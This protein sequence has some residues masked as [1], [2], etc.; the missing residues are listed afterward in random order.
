MALHVFLWVQMY[1]ATI[2]FFLMACALKRGNCI[3]KIL[4]ILWVRNIRNLTYFHLFRKKIKD[5]SHISL[6]LVFDCWQSD[7]HYLV[8]KKPKCKERKK[9]CLCFWN[10]CHILFL[11]G[12]THC[13]SKTLD[14]LKLQEKVKLFIDNSFNCNTSCGFSL[15]VVLTWLGCS[16]ATHYFFKPLCKLVIFHIKWLQ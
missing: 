7:N 1:I 10:P 14:V 3:F 4:K 8:T 16:R 15:C 12:S 2:F 5:V 9:I 11:I 6:S 13:S